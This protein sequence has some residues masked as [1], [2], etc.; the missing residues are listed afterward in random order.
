M[1]AKAT[2]LAA[3]L[4]AI[5]V[6]GCGGS[7]EPS[8]PFAP[9]VSLHA[10]GG[11]AHADKPS[12]VLRVKTRPGDDNIHSVAVKLPPVLLVDPTALSGF[13]TEKM[14]SRNRC[15]GRKR[16]GA[17]SAVSSAYGHPLSGPVYAVTGSGRLPRLAYVLH[18]GPASVV[19]R[20]E[21]LS[22]GGRLGASVEELPDTPLHSFL[23]TI[24]G[25]HSG[26]LILSRDICR[27]KAP[28]DASFTGQEG[29]TY[30]TK[31]P[32]EANCGP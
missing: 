22:H 30:T 2:L 17:A 7:S 27:S 8:K 1:R 31:V 29:E 4:T 24:L 26:Y 9:Q 32:L 14:L 10:V 6:A 25:G 5:F 16:L 18:S 20:G 23:F 15:A 11:T 3:A 28:A 21:I 12:I 13:C 19:L